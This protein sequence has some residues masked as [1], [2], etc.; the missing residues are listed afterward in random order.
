MSET[1]RHQGALLA[2][3]T[4]LVDRVRSPRGDVT[5]APDERLDGKTVLV[6]GASRGLGRAI[7]NGVARLGANVHVAV[8]S[9]ADETVA[10]VR[11][12]GGSGTVTAWPLDLES[13]ES[14]D[15]LA[16]SLAAA[17]VRLDVLVLNA[18]VVPLASRTTPYGLDVMLQVNAL[19]NIRLVDRLLAERVLVP[20]RE[21]PRVVVVGSE[22]HRS[23]PP[24]DWPTLASPRTYG[25]S[26]VVSEYGRTKL[27]LH[28]WVAELSRRVG[29]PGRHIEVHHLCP[30]AIASSIAREAP[31]WSKPLLDL[32]FRAFFQSPEV[33]A[34][35]VL[36]LAASRA[37]AGQTGVYLH[38]TARRE[39]AAISTS[40]EQGA[41]CW[42]T[43]HEILAQAEFQSHRS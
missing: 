35:P 4:G 8:R 23:S 28:T 42:T 3:L 14:V 9:L 33:A 40:P 12:Q 16:S 13:L 5:L 29:G 38:M 41:A 2:T 10:D 20:E 1:R 27:V 19:S 26:Q 6:T 37:L 7:A 24:I 11:A 43:G 36:Y 25:T 17:G 31:S 15:A 21:A 30:G 34:R 39:P 32:T 18:G 22:A